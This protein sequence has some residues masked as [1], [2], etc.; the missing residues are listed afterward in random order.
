MCKVEPVMEDLRSNNLW[1]NPR[2]KIAE[3]NIRA[4]TF[5]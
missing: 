5:K 1:S 3:L 4:N 2:D